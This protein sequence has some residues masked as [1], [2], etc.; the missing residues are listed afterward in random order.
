MGTPNKYTKN[1]L[2]MGQTPGR[3]ERIGAAD[4]VSYAVYTSLRPRKSDSEE[5]RDS[6]L[7]R[8][9]KSLLAGT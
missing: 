5:S 8:D 7:S 1:T 3:R 4:V 9:H 2:N 6:G